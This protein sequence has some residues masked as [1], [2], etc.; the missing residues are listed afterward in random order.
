LADPTL[1]L[2]WQLEKNLNTEL[3]CLIFLKHFQG[4]EVFGLISEEGNG[5]LKEFCLVNPTE[6]NLKPDS[7]SF[8]EAASVPVD[9]LAAWQALKLHDF[10]HGENE[11]IVYVHGASGFVGQ[12]TCFFAKYLGAK[13]Y[14][15]CRGENVE[16]LKNLGVDR[17]INYEKE[18][19]LRV[20]LKEET[21]YVAFFIDFVNDPQ[22]QENILKVLSTS[23]TFVTTQPST[24]VNNLGE[25]ISYGLSYACKKFLEKLKNKREEND[26]ISLVSKLLSVVD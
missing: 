16:K 24:Y 10:D 7:W 17:V 9:T 18:D 20:L 6:I 15:S 19:F 4:D 26:F 12:W 14:A 1:E 3:V 5:T 23:G 11:H 8:E 13:V 21:E 22:A 25:T 2:L